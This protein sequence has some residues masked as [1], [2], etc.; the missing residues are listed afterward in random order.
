VQLEFSPDAMENPFKLS[1][2]LKLFPDGMNFFQLPPL[3]PEE[4]FEMSSYATARR[5]AHRNHSM[6]SCCDFYSIG[7]SWML[8]IS[9][10][11]LLCNSGILQ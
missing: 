11:C 2:H 3:P 5:M 8:F 10:M 7:C 6:K 9:A 4:S 1:H